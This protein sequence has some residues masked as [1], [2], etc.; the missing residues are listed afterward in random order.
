MST[1]SAPAVGFC[2]ISGHCKTAFFGKT[3][4]QENSL[5]R[6]TVRR[7]DLFSLGFQ[8]N[9]GQF[10]FSASTVGRPLYVSPILDYVIISNG[11][12]GPDTTDKETIRTGEDVCSN[13]LSGR[14]T[15]FN[16]VKM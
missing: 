5:I 9:H 13:H 8:C 1:V 4:K 3:S 7:E 14:T 6:L 10:L 2:L 16:T 15:P 12:H 11:I